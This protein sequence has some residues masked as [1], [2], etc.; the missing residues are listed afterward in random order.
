MR[1]G[2]AADGI[3][4][5]VLSISALGMTNALEILYSSKL[6]DTEKCIFLITVC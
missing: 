3:K 6:H 2:D 1:A 4:S 5:E